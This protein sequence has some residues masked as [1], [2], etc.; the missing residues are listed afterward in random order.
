MT[1][2]QTKALAERMAILAEQMN[3]GGSMVAEHVTRGELVGINNT[4]SIMNI[5][6]DYEWEYDDFEEKTMCKAIIV[7]G[8][9]VEVK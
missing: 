4:L 9:R 7:N 6:Y 3:A 1:K 8:Y 2:K 5:A